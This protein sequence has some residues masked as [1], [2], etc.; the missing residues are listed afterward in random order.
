MN[1]IIIKAD[2]KTKEK[3]NSD[4][5]IPNTSNIHLLKKLNLIKNET[6]FKKAIVLNNVGKIIII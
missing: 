5:L 6:E 4:V 1:V 2:K 3:L